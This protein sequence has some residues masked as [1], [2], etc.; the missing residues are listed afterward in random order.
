MKALRAICLVASLFATSLYAQEAKPAAPRAEA[1][2]GPSNEAQVKAIQDYWTPERLAAALPMPLPRVEP[3][4]AAP[5]SN[6]PAPVEPARF[7][8]AILPTLHVPAEPE[9][10]TERFPLSQGPEVNDDAVTPDAFNYEMPFNNYRTGI[11]NQ[12]PYT[13]M[14]KLFFTVPAGASEPA[15]GYVCS[16]AVAGNLHV[17]VTAR[18]CMWDYVSKKWYSNWVFY[19]GWN[20]GPDTALGGAWYPDY[21]TTWTGGNVLA[22][23]TGWDIGILTMEG[24]THKGCGASGGLEIGNYTGALGYS[25]NGDYTQRQWNAFGYPQAAPFEGNYLYQDNGA[26]GA[27]NPYG[28]TNV[29]EIGDPQTGGTSGGPWVIS[30]NPNNATDPSPNNNTAPGYSNALNGVNSYVYTSPAE[31]Y[32]MNGTIFQTAN[33]YNLFESALAVKCT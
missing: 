7:A 14:G 2:Q 25:Y 23:N 22:L 24:A 15:G 30:F 6:P 33:F 12:F 26:T 20:N 5:D 17:V 16:A 21:A 8:P 28:S 10:R 27:V 9:S 3:R 29:V 1:I 18:H 4:A 32:A 19:P 11:N 13:A 31:P